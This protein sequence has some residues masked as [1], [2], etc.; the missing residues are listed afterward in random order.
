MM[1]WAY[2]YFHQITL[3]THEKASLSTGNSPQYNTQKEVRHKRTGESANGLHQPGK[4]QIPAVI[5]YCEKTNRI[6][7]RNNG[8]LQQGI[9]IGHGLAQAAALCPQICIIPFSEDNE[10]LTLVQ[11]AHQLYPFV[12]L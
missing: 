6:V 2:L 11:L 5:V 7:Q 1:L 3:D 4:T 9:E 12:F 10:R 8:A